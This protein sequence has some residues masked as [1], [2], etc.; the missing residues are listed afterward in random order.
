MDFSNRK[1]G[2]QHESF[3]KIIDDIAT[4]YGVN[5]QFPSSPIDPSLVLDNN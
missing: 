3:S 2:E 4:K 1:F 5:G